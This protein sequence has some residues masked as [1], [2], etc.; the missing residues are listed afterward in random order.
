MNPFRNLD[1][2]LFKN[3]NLMG[4]KLKAQLRLEMF[5]IMNN[6][7]LAPQTF[8]I[9]NNT[10]LINPNIGTPVAPTINAPRQIQLG[11]RLLF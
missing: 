9:F 4:E 3:Q 2:S 8:T 11:L 10:G 6:T 5:N 1:F 7:N